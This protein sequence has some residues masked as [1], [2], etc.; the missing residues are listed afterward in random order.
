M[1]TKVLNLNN[2]NPVTIATRV[3]LTRGH[4]HTHTHIHCEKEPK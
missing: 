1:E 3:W 2:G 4:T